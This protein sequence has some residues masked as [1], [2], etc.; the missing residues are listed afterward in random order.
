MRY[1]YYYILFFL[2]CLSSI[3][4]GQNTNKKV[5]DLGVLP[6]SKFV[7][8]YTVDTRT[9]SDSYRPAD[10]QWSTSPN[11]VFYRFVAERPMS[12]IAEASMS[13]MGSYIYIV[14]EDMLPDPVMPIVKLTNPPYLIYATVPKGT[15][16]MI[17]EG[18]YSNGLITNGIIETRMESEPSIMQYDLGNILMDSL[19]VVSGDTRKAS[20]EYGN[21]LRKDIYYQ[22]K[23]NASMKL[24]VSLN[25][26]SDLK[27]VNL[28]LLNSSNDL[29]AT[30]QNGVLEVEQL[31]SE[32]YYLIVEGRD[33]DGIFS[34]DIRSELSKTIIDLGKISGNRTISN[35]FNT[36]S[37][38][39]AFGLLTNEVFYKLQLTKDMDISISNRSSTGSTDVD[40][41]TAIYLLDSNENII[42][43]SQNGITGLMA[44]KLVPGTYYVVSE[45]KTQNM[46]IITEISVIEKQT[47]PDMGNNFILTRMYTEADGSDSRVSIDYFD[48][49]GRPSESVLVAA[50]PLGK[51]IISQQDYD[52]FGRPFREWL[53]RVSENSNGQ[54]VMPTDFKILSPDIY[55]NDTHPYSMV[56]Y[57][58][59]SLNRVLQQYSPGADWLNNGKC[60]ATN[61]K[62]NISESATLNCKLYMVGGSSQSPTLIQ[63][64]SYIT[65]QLFVTEIKDEDG[66]ASY[67]I[68]D[69][70]GQ[71]VLIRQL[72]GNEIFDTYYVYD[73]SGNVCF[74]LPPKI[75]DEGIAQD[76]IDLLAYQ[77]RYD[78][79][80]R[81]IA[82]KIPGC[83]WSYFIYDKADRLIFSQDGE[84]RVKGEWAFSIPDALGRIVLSGKC[85]NSFDYAASPLAA[86]VVETNRSDTNNVYKGYAQP[87]GINLVSPVI[88]SV[89]YYDDYT[90][91]GNNGI[92]NSIDTQ[93]S[94]E[95]GYG[96]CYGDHQITNKYKSKGLLTGILTAQ[97]APSGISTTYLYSVMYYDSNGRLI[98]SKSS[99]HLTDGKDKEYVAYNFVGQP[100]KRK[101]VHSATGKA[102]QTEI[103]SY[104]YDH[105]GRLLTTTH[106]LN[107][108]SPVV[109][110][111]NEYDEL[112]RLKSNN[113][114]GNPNLKT[115]YT[116]N[117][118]SWV[119]SIVGPLFNESLYYNERRPN[120]TNVSCY[121]GNISGI[122][123]NVSGDKAR[124]YNF[125]YD[126]L[127]RLT[128]AGYLEGNTSSDKFSTFYS[129][130]K[131]GNMLNLT[132]HGN[133]GT[134]TYGVIDDLIMSYD[135]NQLVSVEDK[136]A[137][138]SLSMSMDFKD[139]SH[140]SVEYAYD[141]NGNMVKDLN[142]GISMIEYNSLN[143]PRRVSF[144]GLN[145]PVNEYVYSAD[146]KKLSVIHKSSTEKRTDYVGNLIYENGSLKRILVDG[147]YIEN[148]IYHFY[149]QDHLG[150]NRVVAK[151]DGTV[152]Q[153]THYYPY[154]MSFAEGT[155]ADKQP[156][157]YNGKELDTENGLNLYDYGARQLQAALGRFTT[158]D[159]FS[160]KY[161]SLSPYQYCANN[162]INNLDINGDSIWYT[163]KDNIV[164]MHVTAKVINSSS[165]NINMR[166]AAR[167]IAKDIKYTYEGEFEWSDG[168]TYS[169]EIDMDLSVAKSMDDVN[170]SDHLFVFADSNGEGARGV[171]S[172]F[173][174]KVMTLA[175]SDYVNWLSPKVTYNKTFT[176]THEFGHAIGLEHVNNPFNIMR[177]KGLFHLSNSTQRVNMLQQQKNINRGPN[178]FKSGNRKIPYP[179]V[180]F[181][182]TVVDTYKLGLNWR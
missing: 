131:H 45:G 158:I 118:R 42:Q 152:V 39:N 46:S 60:L 86:V 25:S 95:S 52:E 27:N 177:S 23:M 147:G 137:N 169:L 3:V 35:T 54:F 99:N 114:N 161:Y 115:D 167:D 92:P 1:L 133:I 85:N 102:T 179:F 47:D 61:Y 69:K 63:G 144:T 12:I 73:D 65:G 43:S 148:G 166:A 141:S 41:A 122:D 176:A 143:L 9:T 34:V 108:G 16:Y 123:W 19:R 7:N 93:Y 157:K 79:R 104:V 140:E 150:N 110:V 33:T 26:S 66:N 145:N 76:K 105:A 151:S 149:L 172:M 174:G 98:Q 80:N 64:G 50:S 4:Y 106:Q 94:A 36:T 134:T 116:Y 168:N 139:G 159:R 146:G 109:L 53:P 84:Q 30:S 130:D 6:L 165:D 8:Y 59:S 163:L 62:T 111:S 81:C 88:L 175:S 103:Y 173:G 162:P 138:P 51:D 29:I 20:N 82:K 18:G 28:Y 154:G 68:K 135:G 182:G 24:S 11:D 67:E 100:I 13:S 83:D 38:K 113:R 22:F 125:S 31:P 128:G 124:G 120:G 107:D 160:E 49:L 171:T 121:N 97:I 70:L 132:R 89:N 170:E 91:L 127:S 142:K 21:S 87:S 44:N 153:T 77:Y 57:E 119:K 32:T 71:I 74:V 178:S 164:T 117:V 56:I 101:H 37:S 78:S 75:N 55:N 90:F 181:S 40:Y 5:I 2:C 180:H 48:G 72:K 96:I 126:N 14:E 17:V 136:G 10:W 155:F 58:N 129:Y 15:Y 156:Y 112:G